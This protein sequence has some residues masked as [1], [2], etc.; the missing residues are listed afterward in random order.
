[1]NGTHCFNQKGVTAI[2]EKAKYL[3]VP[4]NLE[5]HQYRLQKALIM[6]QEM[7]AW[8]LNPIKQNWSYSRES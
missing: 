3:E 6:E 2:S 7:S 8:E 1:M 5:H 4:Y